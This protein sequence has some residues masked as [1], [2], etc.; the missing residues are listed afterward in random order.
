LLPV[1]VINSKVLGLAPVILDPWSTHQKESD[2]GREVGD[3]DALVDPDAVV[4]LA[5]HVTS[6]NF[7]EP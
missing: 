6:A 5:D 1:G 7:A 3:G 4:V 2:E